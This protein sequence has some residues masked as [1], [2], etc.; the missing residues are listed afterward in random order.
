MAER[1]AKIE[2]SFM[3]DDEVQDAHALAAA[4][5]DRAMDAIVESV[6]P[7]PQTWLVSSPQLDRD[8][9]REAN[10]HDDDWNPIDVCRD[11]VGSARLNITPPITGPDECPHCGTPY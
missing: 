1:W 2:V 10:D 5:V 9:W 4:A 7:H 11:F 6:C 3:Y 8:M